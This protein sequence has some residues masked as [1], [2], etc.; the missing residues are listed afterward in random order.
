MLKAVFSFPPSCRHALDFA[1]VPG[2]VELSSSLLLQLAYVDN[3]QP[4]PVVDPAED[5][6]MEFGEQAGVDLNESWRG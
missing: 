2:I 4:I 3:G 5:F 1:S 6:A